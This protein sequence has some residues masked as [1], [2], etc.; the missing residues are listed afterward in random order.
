MRETGLI[1]GLGNGSMIATSSHVGDESKYFACNGAIAPPPMRATVILEVLL[2]VEELCS[3]GVVL[4][5][6]R[7]LIRIK[8]WGVQ[9]EHSGP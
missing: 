5:N 7:Y 8:S 4:V 1:P 6:G 9:W 2:M 3:M